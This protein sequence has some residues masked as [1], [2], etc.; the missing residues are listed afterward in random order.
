MKGSASSIEFLTASLLAF[1][2]LAAT[3][4][5]NA[6]KTFQLGELETRQEARLAA[7]KACSAL[8]MAAASGNGYY[9]AVSNPASLKGTP[10][11]LFFAP[12]AVAVHYDGKALTCRYSGS[13]TS[14]SGSTRFELNASDYVV[15]NNGG[16]VI[17]S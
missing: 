8:S 16:E 9:S 17:V 7:F 2:A 13:V 12:G 5:L 11:S 14:P 6:G 4:H 3:I 1:T 15:Y 10:Y